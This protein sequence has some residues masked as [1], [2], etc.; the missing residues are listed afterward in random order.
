MFTEETALRGSLALTPLAQLLFRLWQKESSGLLKIQNGETDRLYAFHKGHLAAEKDSF[1]GKDFAAVLIKKNL[2][3]PARLAKCEEHTGRTNSSLL[4]AFIELN[5]LAPSFLWNQVEE[6]IK[7]NILPLFDWAEGEYAFSTTTFP[8]CQILARIKTLELILQGVR[9]MENH[10]LRSAH[11][12]PESETL[13]TYSPPHRNFIPLE[14]HE[15]YILHIIGD[16]PTLKE[17]CATSELGGEETRNTV[18]VLLSVGLVGPSPQKSKN[19]HVP[20]FSPSEIEKILSVFNE[21]CALIHKYISKEIG[22]VAQSVLEKSLE[23]IRPRLGPPFQN[24]ELRPDGRIEMKVLLKMS[25]NLQNE[26]MKKNLVRGLNEILA[27]E[28]LAVKKTFGS[29]HE[30]ALIKNFEKMGE[31]G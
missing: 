25:L 24:L 3:D 17:L 9:R 18:Y 20:D 19:R 1:N 22:P 30:A 23:E 13:Q 14:P 7:E 15:K 29:E 6:Y 27:A 21:K 8:E 31:A 4:R 16:S 2:L 11:L 28:V 26:D 10:A 12:P 5:L